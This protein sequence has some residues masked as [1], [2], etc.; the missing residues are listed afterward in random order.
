MVSHGN[1]DGTS[2]L[3][4]IPDGMGNSGQ[5]RVLL[6]GESPNCLALVLKRLQA[7]GC[8]CRSAVSLDH[9][10][11][12]LARERFDVLLS[13]LTHCSGNISSLTKAVE[14]RPL[15]FFH[16]HR[17]EDSCW[18]LPV[19]LRGASCFGSPALRPREFAKLLDVLVDENGHPQARVEPPQQEEERV[20]VHEETVERPRPIGLGRRC[21]SGPGSPSGERVSSRKQ[22]SLRPLQASCERERERRTFGG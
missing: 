4:T 10:L 5:V 22:G 20:P 18:W 12:L 14:G 16:A 13:A 1:S 17:V 11:E 19:L 6:V 2:G 21:R 15:S 9:A 3:R 8:E 7:Q